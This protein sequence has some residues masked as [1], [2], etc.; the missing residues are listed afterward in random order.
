MENGT[1]WVNVALIAVAML[2]GIAGIIYELSKS[3]G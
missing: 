1:D 2:I 3:S